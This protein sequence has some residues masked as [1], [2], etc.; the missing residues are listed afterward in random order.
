MER[1]DALSELTEVAG[2][3]TNPRAS[4][5]GAL[6]TAIDGTV[7][8]DGSA[9]TQPVSHAAL[10]ELAAAI[11]TEL[12]VDVVGALPAGANTIGVVDLGAVDNAV[13][14]AIAASLA[15]LDDAVSG[16]ELQVDVVGALPA[17]DNNIGNVD[18]ASSALPTGA[19]TA[20]N[21]A[22]IIG[23]LDG[24]EGLLT[25]IDAD[26]G[27]LAV[28]GNGTAAGALRVTVASDT[29]GVLSVDDNGGTLTVDDGGTSLT[30]DGTV[31]AI[32]TV[33]TSGGWTPFKRVSTADT[34]AAV[35][36]S[37]AGQV[38]YIVCSNVN[39]AAR[40][41]KLYDKATTPTVGTDTPVHTFIIPGNT[42]GAGHVIPL[43]AAGGEFASGIGIALT[44]LPADDETT[45]VAAEEL[46]VNVGYA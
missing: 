27:T 32:P 16:L 33:A 45:G 23:H 11:D 6:W 25:T 35:V 7:T 38:G 5:N 28:T 26:T 15:L 42:A 9:V 10:T 18:V 46:V 22:T 3:W 24:V 17:G 36:K 19:S 21:Q 13:L 44:T 37:S 29:T 12:Q 41:L 43:G 4:A 20:A 34:N 14:D 30:V 2:D 40:Y 8:V 39:A 1:D 31:S